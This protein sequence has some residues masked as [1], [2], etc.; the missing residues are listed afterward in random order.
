MPD[1]HLLEVAALRRETRH[2][3]CVSLA[4]PKELRERFRFTPGQ[5][6]TLRR[7][8]DGVE[9]RRTYSI[10]SGLDEP[11]LRIGIKKV[12]GGVF[13]TWANEQLQVGETIEVMPPVGRFHVPL[14]PSARRHFVAFAAG[15]GITPIL[16]II[17]STLAHE[18]GSEFTLFYGNRASSAIM[19]KDELEDLKDRHLDRFNL[20]FILSREH[21]EIDLLNGRISRE[22]CDRL[23]EVWVRPETIAHAFVCGPDTLIDEVRESL[24]AHGLSPEQIHVERFAPSSATRA[25][26]RA[27]PEHDADQE[28]IEITAIIDGRRIRFTLRKDAEPILEAALRQGIALPYSCK[29]GICATCRAKLVEG[30]VDMDANFALEDYEVER[31]FIL[32]CQSYPATPRVTIDF[33]E[34]A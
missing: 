16:S 29:G 12:P 30:E 11:D 22:K 2:A 34:V 15:S 1:F 25:V 24:G 28:S 4:V 5:H 21:Q 26:R 31:G 23:L 10:C 32:C 17:R 9:A 8:F 3:V 7:R 33:D 18:P 14:D 6:L 20:A 13:S 19:F 27:E